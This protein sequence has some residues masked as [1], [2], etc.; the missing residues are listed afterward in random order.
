MS[1]A[2]KQPQ[3]LRSRNIDVYILAV[4][5]DEAVCMELKKH[6]TPVIRHANIP[7]VILS[8]FEIIPGSDVASYKEQLFKCEIVLALLSNDYL[9]S[10][11]IYKRAKRVI[12]R[13]NRS[14][15]IILPIMVR[16]CMWK[17]SLYANLQ[18]LPKNL[19]PLNNQHFW[20]SEDDALKAV[21]DEICDTIS[22]FQEPDEHIEI[23]IDWRDKYNLKANKRRGFAYLLDIFVTIIPA[24]L[25]V[26]LLV[27]DQLDFDSITD[28]LIVYGIPTLFIVLICALFESSRWRGTP[29]KMIM[30]MQT[31]DPAGNRISFVKALWRNFLRFVI[32][33]LWVLI[34]PEIIRSI[35]NAKP[36]TFGNILL[37]SIPLLI[38]IIYFIWKKKIIHDQIT[39]TLV[40]EKLISNT[41][42]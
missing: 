37:V 35:I 10:D 25:F 7:I 15:T 12:E 1:D 14:E 9:H 36:V 33:G 13:Y 40:G 11:A 17:S 4:A 20:N 32:G 16:N 2:S 23:K 5:E 19:Q 41:D 24:Y 27:K 28:H 34:I 3:N 26:L 38:Q 30:K 21:V 18:L 6:L 22:S 8:D 39:H 31:T 42:N 29:G